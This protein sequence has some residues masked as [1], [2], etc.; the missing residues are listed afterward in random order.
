M[1][2]IPIKTDRDFEITLQHLINKY[3]EQFE[4]M[5]G[6][7][8]QQLNFSDFIDGFIDKN[9]ADITI[10]ANANASH[11]DVCSLLHEQ[12][13]SQNKLFAFN[14]LF[15]EMKKKYGLKV[16]REWLEQEW[17]GCYYLHDAP[18]ATFLPYCFTGDTKIFTDSGTYMIN[19]LVDQS[20][21]VLNKFGEWEDAKVVYF[22]RAH[23]KTLTLERNG[24]TI[25]INCTGNHRWFIVN[26]Y[27][28][29]SDYIICDTDHL[30]ENMEIPFNTL[31][32]EQSTDKNWIVKSI[33]D[34][35]MIEDVYCAVVPGS[36]S[37]T[38]DHNVLT[39]NCYA[40]DLTRL[41]KEGLFFL[42]NY[43]N[44]SPK[45]LTTFLD[46]VIEFVSFFSNRS[47]GA[48]GLSN[49]LL[50]T[51]Y[52]WKKDVDSGYYI[53][54]PEYYIRQNF[55]K[56]IY[57]V[58]QPFLRVDQSSFVNVSIFDRCYYESLFGGVEFE[59]GMFAIDFTEEFIEHQKIF[60]EVVEEIR[61]KQVFAFPV[62]TYSLLY[63]DGHFVDEEFARWC[64]NRG[65]IWNDS[66][67]FTSS[68]V[69]V[70]SNCCRLLSDTK[71]LTAFANSIGGTA[72]S[73]GSVKVNTINL[74]RIA[75]E[76]GKDEETYLKILADRTDLCCKLLSVQR[77]IIQRNIEKGLL[78]NYCEGGIELDKQY[79]TVGCLA[80]AEV[81]DYF[82]YLSKD[83]FGNV[84]YSPA[85]DAFADKIFETINNIKDNFPEDF[86]FNLESVPGERA[87]VILAQ[88]D[89][90]LFDQDPNDKFIYSNQW[91]PLSAK[92]TIEEKVRVSARLDGK[93]NGG[94]I[95]H[96]NLEHPF[97][98]EEMAWDIL[99]YIASQGVFYFAFNVKI[100][101]CE[102]GHGF[103]GPNICP[104]CHSKAVDQVTRIVGYLVPTR[105]YSKERKREYKTRQWYDYAQSLP[106]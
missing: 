75:Y 81:M 19:T 53:K 102:T 65:R 52:F 11:H 79:S 24:E 73:I 33:V 76:S 17:N 68:D 9:T 16:A 45:H 21:K 87:A 38:L 46:D 104:H 23:I 48:C 25:Q 13:K 42:Q 32:G 60:M 4:F 80:L 14:K 96:I 69:G 22:G 77:H 12:T 84:S 27:N 78:P 64:C 40:Y 3:G 62:L 86:S 74:M 5:N 30:T 106:E 39:H 103:V 70:L 98:N 29:N 43:N 67:W 91:I 6:F 26:S 85:A 31:N 37:F 1:V 50:W 18:S 28:R 2:N 44:E 34:T 101:I 90:L 10:D 92:C 56:F 72:L 71:K 95:S 89:N 105:S 15:Y 35:G 93:V 97:N 100:N 51:F 8:E 82:G 59:D 66:N 63:K 83:E 7:H 54:D 58:N 99:N 36:Q 57:R 49:L 61:S 20:I 47:S 94:A 88:K 41:A 55:Q